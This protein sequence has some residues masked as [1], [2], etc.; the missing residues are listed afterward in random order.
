M[1]I[2]WQMGIMQTCDDPNARVACKAGETIFPSTHMRIEVA[3]AVHHRGICQVMGVMIWT[4]L[5]FAPV[6][7]ALV[8]FSTLPV[9]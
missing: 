8:A 9:L 1:K 4:M 3:V 2:K 7:Q 6:I 5:R